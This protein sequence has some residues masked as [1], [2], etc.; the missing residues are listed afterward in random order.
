MAN[1]T[2]NYNLKK[3]AATDNYSVADQNSNMELIDAA[4]TP[5]AD[6]SQVP[7]GSTGKLSQW[8][9]WIT[10]RIKA[11][12]GA[13]NWFDAPATTLQ[14]AN[15]HHNAAAP[16]TGHETPAGAQIKA[17]AAAAAAAATVQS[18]LNTHLAE[19][20]DKIDAALTPTADPAQV[21][22]GLSGKLSQ[23]VSWITNRIKAITGATNWYDAPATTLSA[24]NT[25]ANSTAAHSATSAATASRIMARD[26]SGRAKVA[27]PAASDDI[28]RKD[29]VDAVQSNVDAH[30]ADLAKHG[31]YTDTATNKKYQLGVLNGLLY[32]KEVI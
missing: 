15:T 32:Y 19:N 2:T 17:D 25:H 9:S 27:A 7:T 6:S 13:A 18:S 8:V 24:A 12:T 21:P 28:A 20:M 5:T 16:H 31:T 26:S 14:A 22:T 29:T 11:V 3:P 1:N 10:N 4:L 23:W 30:L